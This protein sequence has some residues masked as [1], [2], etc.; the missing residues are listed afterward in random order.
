MVQAFP[1]RRH[2]RVAPNL[3]LSR[4]SMAIVWCLTEHPQVSA[5]QLHYGAVSVI[6][7]VIVSPSCIVWVMSPVIVWPFC[8]W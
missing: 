1:A 5:S 4:E 6:W 7:V 3:G 2:L 8:I